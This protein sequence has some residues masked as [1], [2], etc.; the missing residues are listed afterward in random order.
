MRLRIGWLIFAISV[1]AF[2]LV[3]QSVGKV[4]FLNRTQSMPMGIYIKHGLD[5]IVIGDVIVFRKAENKSDLIKY[6]AAIS[7]LEFCIDENGAFWVAGF[8]VAQ[9]NIEKYP[10]AAPDQSRCHRLLDDEIFVLGDHPNSYDS[11]YFGP[12]KYRDVIARL[13]LL[14]QFK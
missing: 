12:I 8:P 1:L 7:P 5:K 13:A 3:T 11:R 14:W 10:S 6:V 9:I 4:F 2:A